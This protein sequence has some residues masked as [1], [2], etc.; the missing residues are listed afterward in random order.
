MQS[1]WRLFSK[2]TDLMHYAFPSKD[3]VVIIGQWEIDDVEGIHNN[4]IL[5]AI[6]KNRGWKTD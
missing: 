6:S 3:E 4:Q 2:M 1:G 5:T